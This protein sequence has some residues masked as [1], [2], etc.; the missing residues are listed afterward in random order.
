MERQLISIATSIYAP[1]EKTW[2]YYTIPKH[3]KEWNHALPEWH[4]PAAENDLRD[5]G[6]FSYRM[7]ARDGSVGF[8]F[9]GRYTQ[10]IPFEYIAYTLGDGRKAEFHFIKDEKH[11]RIVG[12]FESESEHSADMQ[13]KGWQ[14]IL[15]NF[16][17]YVEMQ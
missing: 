11:T 9:I 17:A 2:E 7:E 4:C 14:A 6:N 3:I 8:D 12:N 16:R 5:G 10:I 1:V 13:Q 15:D